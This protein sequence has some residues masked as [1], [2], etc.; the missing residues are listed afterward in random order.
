MGSRSFLRA[1]KPS[2]RQ[3][4]N[5][6]CDLDHRELMDSLSRLRFLSYDEYLQ[7]DLWL[8]IREKA[9]AASNR[10]CKF[11]GYTATQIHHTSYAYDVMKGENLNHVHPV[12]SRCHERG[13]KDGEI[14]LP[15]KLDSCSECKVALKPKHRKA[16]GKKSQPRLCS[17]CSSKKAAGKAEKKNQRKAG[18]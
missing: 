15:K 7:S 14:V 17:A 3:K 1:S 5:R 6:M 12:C 10:T 4:N 16:K 11:C 13:H 18:L 8:S 2:F 9:L